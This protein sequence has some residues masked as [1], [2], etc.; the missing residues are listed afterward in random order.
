MALVSIGLPVYNGER[1]ILAAVRSLLRQTFTDWELHVADDGS[2]DRTPELLAGVG[3]PRV[4]V[5]GGKHLGLIGQLNRLLELSTGKYFARMDADDVAYP[6]RLER[7]V[8][9]LESHPEV[10]LVGSHVLVFGAGGAALGKR[11][12]G[13][14]EGHA[15]ISARPYRAIIIVHPTF[16]GKLD[17]F[18][19]YRYWE[20]TIRC[21]DQ[22]MLL[23][24]FRHSTFANVPEILLG[25]REETLGLKKVLKSRWSIM[26]PFVRELGL[27]G[28]PLQCLRGIAEQT[29]K[30]GVELVASATG[31][32]YRTLTHRVEPLTDE[33]R[34]RW[35]LVWQDT[36]PEGQ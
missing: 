5:H 36:H 30:A 13:I 27:R 32:N 19:R 9:F 26:G 35:E 6:Q 23:R 18:R 16:V 25:Y 14:P 1:T 34:R 10:D 28:R 33:E 17:W 3:D 15:A 12:A 31:L 11:A 4:K 22:D 7:Q 20:G 21:E 8:S 29:F 2:T 24:S